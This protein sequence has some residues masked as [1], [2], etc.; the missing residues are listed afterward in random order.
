MAW[1]YRIFPIAISFHTSSILIL[2]TIAYRWVLGRGWYTMLYW[3]M[4]VVLVS[5]AITHDGCTTCCST[6]KQQ[7]IWAASRL[8][9]SRRRGSGVL[10]GRRRDLG[11]GISEAICINHLCGYDSP[12]AVVF[13]LRWAGLQDG[14]TATLGHLGCLDLRTED[15]ETRNRCIDLNS[16]RSEHWT[17]VSY[18]S[19]LFLKLSFKPTYTM[20]DTTVA[21]CPRQIRTSSTWNCKEMVRAW[22]SRPRYDP[23]T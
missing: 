7:T 22:Y 1:L 19:T 11:C 17:Y 2:P 20:P 21:P 5:P 18:L 8:R 12:W 14:G 10:L 13:P 15:R 9:I 23:E 4:F 3:C 6:R 16:R